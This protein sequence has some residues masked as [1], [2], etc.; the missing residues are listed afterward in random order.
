MW[1]REQLRHRG[2]HGCKLLRRN[3]LFGAEGPTIWDYLGSWTLRADIGALII[4][5]LGFGGIFY[6]SYNKEPPNPIDLQSR[7]HPREHMWSRSLTWDS[8]VT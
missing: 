6:Y 1:P 4:I 7:I 2:A 8:K 3:S 5:R